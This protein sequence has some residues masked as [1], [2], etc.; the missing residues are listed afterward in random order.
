MRI[1]YS[2]AYIS[3][4]ILAPVAECCTIG[5]CIEGATARILLRLSATSFDLAGPS[6]G[7]VYSI[8]IAVA[9]G[10]FI[11]HRESAEAPTKRLQSREHGHG[12]A[13]S[14]HRTHDTSGT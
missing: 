4:A 14:V 11:Q 10:R 9:M 13:M 5:S 6:A 2:A 12:V 3:K 7:W 1:Q 8:A